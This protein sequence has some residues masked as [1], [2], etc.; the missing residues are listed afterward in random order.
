MFNYASK[1]SRAILLCHEMRTLPARQQSSHTPAQL[2][3]LFMPV[4]IKSATLCTQSHFL[5]FLGLLMLPQSSAEFEPLLHL[6][7]NF[8]PMFWKYRSFLL[9]KHYGCNF[10]CLTSIIYKQVSSRKWLLRIYSQNELQTQHSANNCTTHSVSLIVVNDF[11][12]SPFSL[13]PALALLQ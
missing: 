5:G 13:L 11:Y 6:E 12:I 3:I 7:S 2:L 1:N 10:S 8:E 4:C 9:E